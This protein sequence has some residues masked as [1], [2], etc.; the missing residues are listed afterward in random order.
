M[1]NKDILTCADGLYSLREAATQRLPARITFAIIRNLKLLQPIVEDIQ[2]T[3]TEVLTKYATRTESGQYQIK[4][5]C[6]DKLN[7]EMN[8]L[9]NTDTDVQLVKIKFEDIENLE[10]T[11]AETESLYWMLEEKEV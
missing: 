1:K 4:D 3:Y 5:G 8:D 9:Y 2:T 7:A 11:L 10:F 6:L